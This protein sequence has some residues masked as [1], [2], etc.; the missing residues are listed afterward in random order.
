MSDAKNFANWDI[1][2][3]YLNILNL[4]GYFDLDVDRIVDITISVFSKNP[5]KIGYLNFLSKSKKNSVIYFI[6]D[7]LKKLKEEYGPHDGKKS[8]YPENMSR[9]L[10][11]DKKYPN[12]SFFLMI[13]NLIKF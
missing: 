3:P 5:D 9:F 1:E 10:K 2:I 12:P 8:I 11:E 7:R 6:I 13:A 4:V